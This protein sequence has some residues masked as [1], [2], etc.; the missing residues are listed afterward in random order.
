MLTDPPDALPQYPTGTGPGSQQALHQWAMGCFCMPADRKPEPE[1]RV[2][3]R[4]L[5]PEHIRDF[6]DGLVGLIVEA[7]I[8]EGK[9][10]RKRG[11]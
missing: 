5:E 10:N 3:P 4:H 8:D 6:V 7:I 9:K 1:V 2:R 11:G